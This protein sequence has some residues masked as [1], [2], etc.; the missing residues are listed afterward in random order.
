MFLMKK[1]QKLAEKINNEHYCDKNCFA[2]H[3]LP[4]IQ[5]DYDSTSKKFDFIS[6]WYEKLSKEYHWLNC[7]YVNG[8]KIYFK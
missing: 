8:G 2:E 6:Y 1:Y 5:R 4:S 7:L 3:V